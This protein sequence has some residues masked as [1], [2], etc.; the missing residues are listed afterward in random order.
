MFRRARDEL[1]GVSFQIVSV[2]RRL[3]A[4]I[5]N[6]CPPAN[7]LRPFLFLFEVGF[8]TNHFLFA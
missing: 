2:Y 3:H 8:G 4:F 7:S 6:I 1:C 5:A